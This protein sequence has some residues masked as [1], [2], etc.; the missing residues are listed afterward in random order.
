MGWGGVRVGYRRC[1]WGEGRG[2]GIQ[3]M[4]VGWRGGGGMHD[5]ML[6]CW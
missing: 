2:G 1:G 6:Q 4:V 3:D 5:V